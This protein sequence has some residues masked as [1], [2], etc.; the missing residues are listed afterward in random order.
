M[1]AAS[2]VSGKPATSANTGS[3]RRDGLPGQG[4]IVTKAMLNGE[5]SQPT[6]GNVTT[7]DESL[8]KCLGD[9]DALAGL[10]SFG[11]ADGVAMPDAECACP[12]RAC[13]GRKIRHDGIVRRAKLQARLEK[14][15][16]DVPDL[17]ELVWRHVEEDI[18]PWI[19]RLVA[20]RVRR[21][22][23][24]ATIRVGSVKIEPWSLRD[25]G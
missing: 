6:S 3:L 7:H 13:V 1:H 5:T 19:E 17:A 18:G 11:V 2:T 21:E 12:C 24:K 25:D 8:C 22:L 4:A 20:E 23:A 9:C 15:G 14:G 16:I 10:V